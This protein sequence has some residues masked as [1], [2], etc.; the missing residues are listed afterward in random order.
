MRYDTR[1]RRSRICEDRTIVRAETAGER[2]PSYLVA[3]TRPNNPDSASAT[4]AESLDQRA[5]ARDVDLGDVLEQPPPP[6]HQQQQPAPRVVV[7]LVHLQVLGQ[8]GDALGQ[9]RDLGLRR[10]G[11]ALMQ[12]VLAQDVFLLFG[13]ERHEI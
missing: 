10:S 7:V 1:E 12:A 4:Q 9:Q 8:V 5:V 11:V 6:A 13:S 3:G 2:K